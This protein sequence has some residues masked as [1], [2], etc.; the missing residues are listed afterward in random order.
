MNKI[1]LLAPAGSPESFKLAIKAGADAI[2]L[3]LAEGFNA[4]M[5]A[6]NFNIENIEEYI[7]YAHI[8]NVKVYV[9]VNT[10]VND[11][12]FDNCLN[13]IF[14]CF[15]KGVDAFII[16]D[17]GL[18]SFLRKNYPN[19]PIH[20]STQA[21]VN[22][23]ES[24]YFYSKL[25]VKRIV[26]SRECDFNEIK[27]IK[28]KVQTELEVFIHG[29]MC[30]SYSGRCTL[31]NVMANRDANKGGCA[32]SCRWMYT[33]YNKDEKVIQDIDVTFDLLST[34]K[35]EYYY[36]YEIVNGNEFI[37]TNKKMYLKDKLQITCSTVFEGETIEKVFL[38]ELGGY[39]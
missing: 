38:I 27:A 9:T 25:G 30:S 24:A 34:D 2:Y 4:R 7:K 37:I 19:I 31:S 21:G 13:L 20:I 39:S 10:L 35:D 11:D 16:Q 17:L 18:V 8:F 33:L 14:D 6:D 5:K 28:D 1:E 15:N 23:T 32:H 26:L 22:N 29:G 12:E 36:E 3:G